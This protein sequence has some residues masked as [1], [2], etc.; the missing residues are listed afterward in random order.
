[1]SE[2]SGTVG[3]DL[4]GVFV[5][6]KELFDREITEFAEFFGKEQSVVEA[7]T[8]DVMGGGRE[9]DNAGVFRQIFWQGGI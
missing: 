9:G 5:S 1:M 6:L 4:D 7:A 8:S 3:A 2:T